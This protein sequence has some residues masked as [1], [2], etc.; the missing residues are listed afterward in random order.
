MQR[1]NDANGCPAWV[2][3]VVQMDRVQRN[4]LYGGGG[5]RSSS[6]TKRSRKTESQT[7]QNEEGILK[8][9]IDD[10]RENPDLDEYDEKSRLRSW[11]LGNATELEWLEERNPK[12]RRMSKDRSPPAL[13]T[14]LTPGTLS[15]HDNDG[16]RSA[17]SEISDGHDFAKNY[18]GRTFAKGTEGSTTII[19]DTKVEP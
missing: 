9:Q 2:T 10:Q 19:Q 12:R 17:E 15:H 11:V 7:G 5:S 8:G 16:S 4:G 14:S 1:A 3:S 13:T 6:P 18:A